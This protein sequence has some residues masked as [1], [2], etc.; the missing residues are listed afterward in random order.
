MIGE[1]HEA[2]THPSVGILRVQGREHAGLA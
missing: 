1:R 2:I